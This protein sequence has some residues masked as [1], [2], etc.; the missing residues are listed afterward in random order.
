M[1]C[2]TCW[3]NAFLC[4][5]FC[6]EHRRMLFLRI[7]FILHLVMTAILAILKSNFPNFDFNIARIK[8]KVR[9]MRVFCST[10]FLWENIK[11][12][13]ILLRSFR[14]I[15]RFTIKRMR[16]LTTK[17]SKNFNESGIVAVWLRWH[18]ANRLQT[19]SMNVWTFPIPWIQF[20]SFWLYDDINAVVGD[21][22]MNFSHL[23]ETSLTGYMLLQLGIL[24]I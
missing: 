7:T 11:L 23:C 4:F 9:E 24:S 22:I 21:L 15:C 12:V 10:V 17:I 18:S 19:S 16:F 3:C 13:F 2:R 5:L 20:R 14:A 1:K 6:L 8:I